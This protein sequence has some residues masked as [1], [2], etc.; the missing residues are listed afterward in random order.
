[1]PDNASF[2]TIEESAREQEIGDEADEHEINDEADEHEISLEHD[3]NVEY[4]TEAYL[5]QL[6]QDKQSLRE[7][8][9]D[10]TKHEKE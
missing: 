2:P 7:T 10:E 9:E 5:Q 6:L 3:I 1:M 4:L 8:L